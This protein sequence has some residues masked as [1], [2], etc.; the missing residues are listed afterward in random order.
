MNKW[1]ILCPVTAMV[2]IGAIVGIL[3]LQ[4]QHRRFISTASSGIGADLIRATNSPHLVRLSPFLQQRLARLLRARTQVAAVLEGDDARPEGDGSACS[5]LVLTNTA[6]D[7]L[8]IRLRRTGSGKFEVVG[9][10]TFTP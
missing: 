6:G 8:L 7:R 5:R 9:F 10:R 1:Q 2:V 4:G 3:A